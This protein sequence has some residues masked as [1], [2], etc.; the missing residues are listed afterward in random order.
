M[1][2][3]KASP[4]VRGFF[5]SLSITMIALRTLNATTTPT[6]DLVLIHAFPL[7]STM[8]DI[9]AGKLQKERP[10]L[11]VHLIDLPGFGNAP[12][13]ERWTLTEAMESLHLELQKK[14]VA[15]PV[16]GGTSMGGYAVLEYYR[17]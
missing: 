13:E 9:A 11:N 6:Q 10:D 14:N 17:L 7:T 4:L 2:Y 3:I 15:A 1:C 12:Y 16:I 5:I 8:Y